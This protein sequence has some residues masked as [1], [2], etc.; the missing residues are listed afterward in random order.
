MP[1]SVGHAVA[2]TGTGDHADPVSDGE[3]LTGIDFLN[4]GDPAAAVVE[5]DIDLDSV[6]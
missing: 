5:A 1:A 3:A 2:A 4:H 6:A